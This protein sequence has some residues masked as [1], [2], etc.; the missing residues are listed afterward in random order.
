MTGCGEC[1][2]IHTGAC[3]IPVPVVCPKCNGRMAGLVGTE[4]VAVA[5]CHVRYWAR[6]EGGKV[7]LAFRR[8]EELQNKQTKLYNALEKSS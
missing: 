7:R 2:F 1:G 5:C 3:P 6:L 4:S 8:R